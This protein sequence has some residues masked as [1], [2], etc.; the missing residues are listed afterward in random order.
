MKRCVALGILAAF[1]IG[2][3]A[4]RSSKTAGP[5]PTTSSSAARSDFAAD[6]GGVVDNLAARRFITVEAAFDVTMKS[7]LPVAELENA[8]R[9]YQE[10]EGT[11]KS[12]GVPDE[13]EKGALT[14]E[15]VPITTATG[16][17]EVRIA[18]HP[19]GTIAG[20]FFLKAGA[21]PP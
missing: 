15:R 5:T 21:P 17:G 11:Y 14:V 9:T 13:V 16:K 3:A 7:K 19:D 6:A 1:L 18:Y 8:W 12:H 20:L 4:C 2:S 10:I